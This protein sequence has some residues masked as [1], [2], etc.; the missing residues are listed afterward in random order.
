VLTFSLAP[1]VAPG[2]T[3]FPLHRAI[4]ERMARVPGIR[5]ATVAFLPPFYNGNEMRLTFH[6]DTRPAAVA[7]ALNPVGLRFFETIGVP[8]VAGRD[9]T[10]EEL[11][12]ADPISQGP[13]VLTETV[14]R[15]V[16]GSAGAAVGQTVI[17]AGNIRRPIVGV[18]RD[19]RQRKLL[20]DDSGDIAFEPYRANWR[21]PW[22]T[23]VLSATAPPDTLWPELRRA[24]AEVVPDAPVFGTMTADQGIRTEFGDDALLSEIALLFAVL[25]LAVAAAGLFSVLTRTV[26]ERRRELG[27]RA[28][29]GATPAQIAALITRE[30]A[31]G[32]AAGAAIGI[33]AS[34]WLSR[35]LASW[36]FGVSRFDVLSFAVAMACVIGATILATVP[37]C[38]QA[39]RLGPATTLR[40]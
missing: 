24:L 23:V 21:T 5:S 14:A 20:N 40:E 13:V 32:L 10:D 17:A 11:R 7:L 35:F 25:A 34:A 38:R 39:M 19:T 29:L 36:L 18:V 2:Q 8:F 33:L 4:E 12:S 3:P 31:T 37:A 27:I 16:F 1:N 22:I 9:F 28:A 15:R 26:A 30:A 6:T